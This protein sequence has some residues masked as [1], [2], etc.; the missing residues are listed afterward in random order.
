MDKDNNKN[1]ERRSADTELKLLN[2]IIERVSDGIVALDSDWHYTYVNE[3]AARLLQKEDAQDLIGKHIWTEYPEGIGQPFHQAYLKAYKTQQVIVFEEYYPP[4]GRWFENRIY[5]S[6]DGLTIYFT[7][8]TERKKAEK[9]LQNSETHLRTLIEALPDLVWL[10]DVDGVY[11]NCNLKFEQLF[12]AKEDEII[13]KTDYDFVDKELADSFRMHDKAA[14]SSGKPTVNEEEVNYASDNHKE[15]LET[16]KTP[17]FAIDG[18]LIGV[19]G[20][21]RDIT[22]RRQ[23]EEVLRRSQKMD[24]VGQLTGGIAHDFN[25]ILGIILGN[26]ELLEPHVNGDEKAVK[27]VQSIE[28]A[29]LR[30]AQL[31]KQLLSY[32]RREAAQVSVLDVNLMIREMAELLSSLLTPQIAVNYEISNDLWLTKVDPGD[33]K[34]ALINLCFNARDSMEGH[35]HLTIE[36]RNIN[37]DEVSRKLTPSLALGQYVE[38]VISDT[39]K[40]IP[41]EHI[42]RIFEP[43]FTT[44]DQGKGTGLGLAMVYAFVK[45]SAGYIKCNSEVGIGTSFQIYLPREKLSKVSNDQHVKQI[46]ITPHGKETILVVDDEKELM[47]LAKDIL[48]SL[49]YRVLTACDGK[50]ALEQLTHAPE[51]GLLFSDIVMPNGMNGYELAEQATANQPGLKVLLTSGITENIEPGKSHIRSNDYL[52][53]KPYSRAELAEQVRFALDDPKN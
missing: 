1:K 14:M 24:A 27:R 38:L 4:W 49:G 22:E 6:E 50:K 36:T 32:S 12:G 5:P 19:L 48:E 46:E 53:G 43:F 17:M 45:R 29:G 9:A 23:A 35:G 8:I 26:L 10:K 13:G 34:D 20:V 30:A 18:T 40:G 33:F 31:T 42:E 11:L 28:E 3:R 37:L 15:L 7:E 41:N 52:L 21:G 44:K 51:I 25:N 39:G 47:E 16:I 2:N